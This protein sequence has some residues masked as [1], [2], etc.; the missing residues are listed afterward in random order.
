MFKFLARRSCE[1]M[2]IILASDFNIY[3]KDNY[4]AKLVEFIKDTFELEV[5]SDLSQG[6]TKLICA[7]IW[8]LDEMWTIHPA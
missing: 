5:L 8:S 4:S 7:S 2:S 1:D 6:T 3:M